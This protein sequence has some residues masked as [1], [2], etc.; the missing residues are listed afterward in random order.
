M[1]DFYIALHQLGR[2]AEGGISGLARRMGVRAQV[3]INKLN[4]TD[5]HA[6]PKIGEFVAMMTDTCNTE[7]LDVLCRMFDGQFATRSTQKADSL[8]AAVIHTINEHADIAQAYE[9]VVADGVVTKAEKR[10]LLKEIAEAKHAL[11]VLENT[12]LEQ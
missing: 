11:A 10:E 2:N 12:I 4:P 8:V 1:D 9:R 5:S 7:P 3:L 6:E